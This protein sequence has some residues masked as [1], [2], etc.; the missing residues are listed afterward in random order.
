MSGDVGEGLLR[1]AVERGV[2]AVVK[3][4][5]LALGGEGDSFVPFRRHLSNH[6]SNRRFRAEF[7]QDGRAESVAN[8]SNFPNGFTDDVFNHGGRGGEIGLLHREGVHAQ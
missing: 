3:W 2:D 8:A 4:S 5:T 6:R 7:V 1:D